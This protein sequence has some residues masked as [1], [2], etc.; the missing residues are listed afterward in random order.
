MPIVENDSHRTL[1]EIQKNTY[2]KI[3]QYQENN[4]NENR[5]KRLNHISSFVLAVFS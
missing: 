4:E 5:K 2:V 1:V 3:K